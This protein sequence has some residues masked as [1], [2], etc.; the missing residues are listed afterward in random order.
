MLIIG[1]D[2]GPDHSA[3]VKFDGERILK[4]VKLPNAEMLPLI[5]IEK[6]NSDQLVIEQVA[7]FGMPV[8]KEVFETVYHSGIFAA[9]FG[10]D[11]VSRYTRI[12]I[13]NHICHSSRATD[14]NIRA[15]II[16]R[17]GGKEKAIGRKDSQG[18]LYELSGDL[19]SALAVCLIHWDLCPSCV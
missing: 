8:G 14:A 4:A 13:K 17:F 6:Y 10:L 19:W 18:P 5:Q 1:L 9:T 11:R 3:I 12:A 2:P 15:A 7:S 16:D